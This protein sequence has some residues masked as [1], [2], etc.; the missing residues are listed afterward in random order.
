MR[1]HGMK[2]G[3]NGVLNQHFGRMFDEATS[4][5]AA[6]RSAIAT[7]SEEQDGIHS[8]ASTTAESESRRCLDAA[9]TRRQSDATIT[10][11]MYVSPQFSC[12]RMVTSMTSSMS[13]RMPRSLCC[14][15]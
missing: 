14:E 15:R 3:I 2:A 8:S 13:R 1:H 6:G 4:S 12:R 7:V 9:K 11:V 5:P 10:I